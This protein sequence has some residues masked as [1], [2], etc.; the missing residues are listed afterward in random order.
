MR[1]KKPGMRRILL[2]GDSNTAGDG[3]SNGQRYSDLLEDKIPSLEVLNFGLPGA[4][5]GQQYLIYR[6]FAAGIEHDL[7]IISVYVTN[8]LRTVSRYRFYTSFDTNEIVLH[9][10]P[11]FQ[12]VDGKLVLNGVPPPKEPINMKYLSRNE[13]RHI[14][15]NIDSQ[16]ILVR[17]LMR[18]KLYKYATKADILWN[19]FKAYKSPHSPQWQLTAAIL[20]EW[21]SNHPKQV[22]LMPLP[23]FFHFEEIKS[24]LNY[25]A[26]FGELAEALPNCTLHDPLPDFLQFPL[27]ERSC[28]RFKVDTQH[29]SPQGHLTLANSMLPTVQRLLNTQ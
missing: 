5:T 19:P 11:Y 1:Q 7:L 8:I 10:K 13:R 9:S 28:F 6:E 17:L 29:Y 20:E 4:C 24:A 3:V 12:L 15:P 2:F 22:L 16:N 14:G 23:T 18:S 25:Q 21:I 27:K 26:R